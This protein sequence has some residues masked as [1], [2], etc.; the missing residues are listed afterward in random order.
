MLD[1][2]NYMEWGSMSM[3]TKAV[4]TLMRDCGMAVEM[5]YGT[6]SIGSGANSANIAPA[7][8]EH[9]SYSDKTAL[10][11]RSNYSKTDWMQM[12]Y[13]ELSKNRP[14]IYT[15]ID[16]NN[17]DNPLG[18]AFVLH[19]Y[20]A[21]GAVY[22][23]WGWNG[24][25]DG[26][27]DIDLLNPD[28]YQFSEEQDMVFVVPVNEGNDDPDIPAYATNALNVNDVKLSVDGTTP[29][30][31]ELNNETTNLM[32]WQCDIELPEG[33]VLELKTNG[34]PVATLGERFVTTGHTISSNRLANGAYRFIATSMDGEAIPGT[35]GVLFTVVLKS[36]GPLKTNTTMTG[37]VT[38][39]EYNTQDNHKLTFDDV[40]FTIT[41]PNND[42]GGGDGSTGNSLKLSDISLM[43]GE[44]APLSIDLENEATNLMGWQCDI[45]LPEGLTLALKNNGKPITVLGERFAT[46]EH[47]ISSSRLANGA[48]RF[49]ATSIDGEA[50]PGTSGTLF[51]VT[52]QADASLARLQ[53]LE[54]SP[55][56]LTGTVTN[57]EFNT[58]GNQKLTL[59]DMT[60]PIII[61]MPDVQKCTTPTI[62]YDRSEL[63]FAC[64]TEGVTFKSEVKV[65]DAKTG[66]GSRIALTQTYVVSVYATKEGYDNSDVATATICWR[67]GRPK[68]D[69]FSSVT[70]DGKSDSDVNG[71]GKVDV[72]DITTI[73]C[74]ISAQAK[75]QEEATE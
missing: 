2:Y 61:L 59:D 60:F 10:Y 22:V 45:V 53:S 27:Y 32:G 74:E 64:K 24:A 62:T 26:Y 36:N 56:T 73:I 16:K 69:G 55:T 65:S 54:A 23:N 40:F 13:E 43:P 50:I 12:I 70:I 42:S 75:K 68:F 71:D 7:L 9:F 21:S 17:E 4:A 5:N 28:T 14:I 30:D 15:G 34:K 63:I 49:I 44:S 52:L 20:N 29:L 46:T 41:V 38:N 33:L 8:K 57:I 47:S 58:Q 66:D 25:F 35:S 1:V 48:Y 51:T 37:K 31:I 72:A 11:K 6:A 19:G 39:I 18:H 3:T 67:N